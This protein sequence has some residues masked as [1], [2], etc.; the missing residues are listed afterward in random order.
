MLHE[1]IIPIKLAARSIRS[2]LG[3]TAVSLLG[4][5]IGV[6]SVILVLAF[7]SGVKGYIVSQVSSFGTD[8]MEIEVKVPKVN[9]MSAANAAGQVGGTQITTFK[10]KD[11]EAVGKL[12]N[13]SA[14][15]AMIISQQIVSYQNKNKQTMLLGVTPG[16]TDVDQQT[17]VAD[18]TMFSESDDSGLQQVAV[19]GSEV[20]TDFFGDQEAVGQNIKVK[21]Q[22]YRV[23]GVLAPRGGAGMFNFDNTVYLP[24]QTMQKKLSGMDYIQSAI[25]KLKDMELLDLTLLQATDIMRGQHHINNPD[26]DDFAVNSIQEVLDILNN[27]FLYVNILLVALTSISLIVGGVGIMNV[28][29]V[30]VTERTFEIGLKKAIGAKNGNI[31]AQ[32]LFEAVFITLLG[33]IIGLVIGFVIAQVGQIAVARFGFALTFPVTWSAAA[34]GI[35]FSAAAGIVFGYFPARQASRLTPIE[36]LRKE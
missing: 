9:K 34:I 20:K 32:F 6:A 1:L 28:M 29:Y 26:D 21:G 2:N 33:G 4:I 24:L 27:V 17:I 23:I 30:T 15:Y 13:V 10:L 14:W 19:L 5:V 12:P 7:G 8:I 11:A 31:L 16:V 25:F 3:R 35:G 36:A 18:G 22:T